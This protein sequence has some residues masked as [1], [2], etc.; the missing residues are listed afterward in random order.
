MRPIPLAPHA[1]STTSPGSPSLIWCGEV[2]TRAGI[3][4]SLGVPALQDALHQA[5]ALR[6]RACEWTRLYTGWLVTLRYPEHHAFF[7]QTLEEALAW[8]LAW[9][10]AAESRTGLPGAVIRV[11]M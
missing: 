3:D 1:A 5:I 6:G 8:C 7:G 4:P 11:V 10:M 2:L 9:I